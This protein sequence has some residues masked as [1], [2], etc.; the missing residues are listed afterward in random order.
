MYE[1]HGWFALAETPVEIDD[2]GLEPVLPEIEPY[3]QHFT[4]SWTVADLRWQN[5]RSFL[6]LYGYSNRPLQHDQ[7]LTDLMEFLAR[8][9]PGSYGMLYER[10]DER[11]TPPGSNAFRVR[12]LARGRV[13]EPADPFLSPCIPVIEAELD[14]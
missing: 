8:R 2:G 14:Q 7:I 1:F 3:L 6:H 12:V 4:A 9:L 11:T 13:T 5:G 10:D